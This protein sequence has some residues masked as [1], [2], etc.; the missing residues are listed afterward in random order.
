MKI[1]FLV[2]SLRLSGGLGV[3]VEHGSRLARDHGFDVTMAITHH[4]DDESWAYSGLE[5]VRVASISDL[6]GEQFDLAIATWWD[7]VAHLCSVS[8]K[9]TAYFVQSLEDRFF[10][11]TD[12]QSTLAGL[13]YRLGLPVVT[14]ARWIAQV[15]RDLDPSLPCY[16]VRNG[17]NKSLFPLAETIDDRPDG[18][19]RILIEGNPGDRIKGVGD[20]LAAVRAMVEPATVTAVAAQGGSMDGVEFRR[21]LTQPEL[22]NLMA[23]SDVLLKLSRV[24][25]MSG[26][27]LEAFH[28][29]ATA[30]LTP[31]TG[32]DEY[33]H[34]GWNALVAGWDDVR[35][36]A[37]LLDLLSRDRAL[38]LRL[39]R[40]ALTTATA[41]PDWDDSAA[42][43][44]VALRAISEGPGPDMAQIAPLLH[45]ARFQIMRDS[46]VRHRLKEK[47]AADGAHIEKLQA[48]WAEA[49]TTAM[50]LGDQARREEAK[51]EDIQQRIATLERSRWIRLL[52]ALEGLL[53]RR[54][55]RQST[56][57]QLRRLRED[58]RSNNDAVD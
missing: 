54:T 22:S 46:R 3:V 7:T 25:G 41:W 38:L 51:L 5:E 32:H 8:A 4:V 24:E 50:A 53:S 6:G 17:I 34:H 57:S 49:A 27:P 58:V 44:A 13:T 21:S 55:D 12:P 56:R 36:T 35:G 23:S 19:L 14:E 28:R 10:E 42:E 16:V 9:R 29:G 48:N 18:P 1:V 39:R 26:P 11:P 45:E 31:V 20:A 15:F 2:P 52:G 40:N 30:V 33:T 37:R 43:M 47:V